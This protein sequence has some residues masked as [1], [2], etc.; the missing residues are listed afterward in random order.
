MYASYHPNP[1]DFTSCHRFPKLGEGCA[2]AIQKILSKV[3]GVTDI[4]TNV[5]D[6][7]VIVTSEDHVSK[8]LL[9][10]KL[11]KWSKVSGKS[12]ELA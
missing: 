11:L 2:T 1:H 4:S 7:K 9:L 3:D 8:D 5:D 6:K 10:E 12:V